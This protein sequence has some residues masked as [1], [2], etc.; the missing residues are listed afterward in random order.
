[1]KISFKI[2]VICFWLA[3]TMQAQDYHFGVRVGGMAYNG[4]LNEGTIPSTFRIVRPTVGLMGDV[5]LNSFLSVEFIGTWGFLVGDDANSSKRWM[6]ERNLSFRTQLWDF[7]LGGR[8]YLFQMW[9]PNKRFDLF[10]KAGGSLFFFNPK[11]NYQG[12]WYELQPL[13]TEGQGIEG[14]GEPYR[15]FGF[16]MYAGF[17][18]EYKLSNFITI[19]MDFVIAITDTDYID[20]VSGRYVDY[21]VLL[22]NNGPLSAALSNRTGEY[23][24]EP[25]GR[26]AGRAFRGSPTVNDHFASG[27]FFFKYNLGY[28]YRYQEPCPKF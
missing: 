28:I 14:F 8:W 13:G 16:S 12:V 9:N 3:F 20:D 1:M 15:R 6:R 26:E 7:Q 18:A 27:A 4:D 2:L 25:P 5:D 23:F 11:A 19:G 24:N 21:N 22:E 10:G 17:G